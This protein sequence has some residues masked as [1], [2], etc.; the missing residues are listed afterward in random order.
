MAISRRSLVIGAA[1]AGAVASFA[2]TAALAAE[3][4]TAVFHSSAP[5][6]SVGEPDG[7]VSGILPDALRLVAARAQ[8][9]VRCLAY[10]WA[11]A[12]EMVRTGAADALVTLWTEEREREMIF[13]RTPLLQDEMQVYFRRDRSDAPRLR[14][15]L[16]P[17]EISGL[18][19]LGYIADGWIAANVP[20]E[21][22]VGRCQL[23][24]DC[25]R[26]LGAGGGDIM[27]GFR[28]PMARMLHTLG[29]ENAIEGA[30][31]RPPAPA[32]FRFG[33]RRSHPDA[34]AIADRIDRAAAAS[35]ADLAAL[36]GL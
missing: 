26:R 17:R 5:P 28:V 3:S 8:L 7:S 18:G 34:A 9:S 36:I 4:I 14:A 30:P 16:N 33:I 1:S 10:P 31:L 22:V 29:L 24:D 11:R 27:F 35:S 6:F 25:V 2:R 23:P 19:V 15:G 13:A 12:Q 21:A 32:L 20:A